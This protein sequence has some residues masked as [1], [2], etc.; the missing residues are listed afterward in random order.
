M[1]AGPSADLPVS[2]L[3]LNGSTIGWT[4]SGEPRSATVFG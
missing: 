2:S 3:A 1:R 4:H